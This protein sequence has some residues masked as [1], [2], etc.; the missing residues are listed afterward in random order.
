[1]QIVIWMNIPSHHQAAFFHALRQA[2]VDLLVRYYDEALL[3]ERRTQGWLQNDLPEG[4]AFVAPDLSVLS[5]ISDYKERIHIVPGYGALF[6][7][8]LA[9]LLSREAVE[10]VHWSECS[11]SGARWFLGYPRK[12]WYGHLVARHALGAFAQGVL[13]KTDFARWGIPLERI[14]F[15]PYVVNAGDRD[16]KTAPECLD[17]LG[18][19]KAFL[20]IGTLCHRKATDVF[21]KAFATIYEDERAEWCLLL[22]GKDSAQGR[23]QELARA[24]G[25]TGSAFFMNAVSSGSVFSILKSAKVLVLP[26]RFDGWGVVLNEGASM[27]LGLIGSEKA[28]SSH[29]LIHPTENG[30]RVRA[31]SVDSLRS[32]L[33]AYIRAPGLAEKHGEASLTISEQFTPERNVQRFVAAVESWR[34]MK[35]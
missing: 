15:L 8:Q 34:A 14:A 26:S 4:E 22:V 17:F 6:L 16:L 30:F 11:R 3:D 5:T 28:G 20:Y 19:R 10:W 2:G 29:H 12:R 31:G 9:A 18:G 32:A 7:R 35:L 23:Y 1:M 21:L 13:A 33:L 25:L 27:E 24:L